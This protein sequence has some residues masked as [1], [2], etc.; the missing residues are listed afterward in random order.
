MN[1]MIERV[2]RGLAGLLS[3]APGDEYE[4]AHWRDYVPEAK[5]AINAMMEPTE[6]MIDAYMAQYPLAEITRGQV[7]SDFQAMIRAALE[8]TREAE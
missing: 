6:V 8:D 1:E 5:A 2:A 3:F 4:N 7:A